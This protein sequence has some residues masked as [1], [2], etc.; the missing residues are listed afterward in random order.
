MPKLTF[1]RGAPIGSYRQYQ[2]QSHLSRDRDL[3]LDHRHPVAPVLAP[4][5][6]LI[7]HT[8]Y[9]MPLWN[10]NDALELLPTDYP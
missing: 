2:Q 10:N 9:P 3:R 1:P 7:V 8:S 4:E 5:R 6:A